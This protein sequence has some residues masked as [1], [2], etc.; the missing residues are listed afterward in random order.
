MTKLWRMPRR[1]QPNGQG[2]S[3]VLFTLA[4]IALLAMAS[5]VIDGGN[6]FAQQRVTQ[7]R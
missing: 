2:Q 6:A 3:L 1:E 5:L 7:N 4:V